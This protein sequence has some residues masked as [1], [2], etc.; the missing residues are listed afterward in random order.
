MSESKGRREQNRARHE[1]E[2]EHE[3]RPGHDRKESGDDPKTH[4][5]IIERRWLGSPPPT[6]ELYAR[7]VQQWQKL[8][9][10]VVQTP[11]GPP[12]EPPK[13]LDDEEEARGDL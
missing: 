9:G 10:A 8:S 11:A 13:L 3:R 6:S 1:H 12:S 7:A 2:H 5:N 4:A